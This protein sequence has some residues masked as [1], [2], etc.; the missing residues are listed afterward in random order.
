[1]RRIRGQRPGRDLSPRGLDRCRPAR[2]CR[3]PRYRHMSDG[4]Y[5]SGLRPACP[6]VH[7]IARLYVGVSGSA[8]CCDL[9]SSWC[10]HLRSS[11]ESRSTAL[12][13]RPMAILAYRAGRQQEPPPALANPVYN[14]TGT[15][16]TGIVLYATYRC[17]D[18]LV[19]ASPAD[20]PRSRE[21]PGRYVLICPILKTRKV[22]PPWLNPQSPVA[23]RYVRQRTNVAIAAR[24]RPPPARSAAPP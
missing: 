18:C 11:P 15:L 9:L 4:R 13:G 16:L 21:I 20:N 22:E 6:T 17:L 2:G 3:M 8:C 23:Q 24:A 19:T 1:M 10:P 14:G 5:S 7:H 12:S